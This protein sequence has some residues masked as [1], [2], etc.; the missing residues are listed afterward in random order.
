M[1]RQM[2]RCSAS[3]SERREG[4]RHVSLRPGHR[5]GGRAD[6]AGGRVRSCLCLGSE[7]GDKNSHWVSTYLITRRLHPSILNPGGVRS[8]EHTRAKRGCAQRRGAH[9]RGAGGSLRR[10]PTR[11]TAAPTGPLRRR[12]L[13]PRTDSNQTTVDQSPARNAQSEK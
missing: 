12:R 10:A 1:V 6:P 5:R 9:K 4:T 2:A 11:V 3:G 8:R 7:F 13:Y